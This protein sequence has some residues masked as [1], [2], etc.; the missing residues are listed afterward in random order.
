MKTSRRLLIRTDSELSTPRESVGPAAPPSPRL[1]PK[2]NP[3]FEHLTDRPSKDPISLLKSLHVAPSSSAT[4]IFHSTHSF[5]EVEDLEA[6]T[7]G[8]ASKLSSGEKLDDP[9]KSPP[10][11][12]LPEDRAIDM[13][14]LPP[15]A[16]IAD[17]LK[18]MEAEGIVGRL[19]V[20]ARDGVKVG[21]KSV[22][23]DD[24]VEDVVGQVGEGWVEV[25][26]GSDK[27]FSVFLKSSREGLNDVGSRDA[28]HTRSSESLNVRPSEDFGVESENTMDGHVVESRRLSQA[29]PEPNVTLNDSDGL[30][31]RQLN[32]S[33]RPDET[34][35]TMSDDRMESNFYPIRTAMII[36]P[37]STNTPVASPEPAQIER[38]FNGEDQAMTNVSSPCE[39]ETNRQL[40]YHSMAV[41]PIEPDP[42]NPPQN[43][44]D[45]RRASKRYSNIPA[46]SFQINIHLPYNRILPI[47][48]VKV[49]TISTLKSLIYPDLAVLPDDLTL[50]SLYL[51]ERNL[52][53]SEIVGEVENIEELGVRLVLGDGDD[54]KRNGGELVFLER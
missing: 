38:D 46:D 32:D 18:R 36:T 23:S 41:T 45:S 31:Q 9:F 5:P 48:I 7:M 49:A 51:G 27:A 19:E 53:D 28:L 50:F 42:F 14:D 47:T 10:P 52:R 17:L 4:D 20:P 35:D 8:L 25:V 30:Q 21:G 15:R 22:S 26:L 12:S 29:K 39:D 24:A 44:R 3:N 34:V 33:E 40:N 2:R 16:T 11:V 54:D 13:A 1:P 6:S 37:T 43:R